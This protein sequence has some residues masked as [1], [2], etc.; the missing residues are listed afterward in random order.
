MRIVAVFYEPYDALPEH[1]IA[2][3]RQR[4]S[5]MRRHLSEAFE[6]LP[7]GDRPASA[8][9]GQTWRLTGH[10][11]ISLRPTRRSPA[12]DPRPSDANP[13]RVAHGRPLPTGVTAASGKR[14]PRRA[15]SQRKPGFLNRGLELRLASSRSQSLNGYIPLFDTKA[16]LRNR[17]ALVP[18][19]PAALPSNRTSEASR[20]FSVCG[21]SFHVAATNAKHNR[22]M[23]V[24]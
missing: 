21:T 13:S 24:A 14:F 4:L 1:S 7:R 5:K 12:A 8:P 18:Q 15:A 9:N 23:P 10:T 22:A 2:Y 11:F 3:S 6:R 19:L 16:K 20:V 17:P